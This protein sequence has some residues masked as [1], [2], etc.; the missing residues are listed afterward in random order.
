MPIIDAVFGARMFVLSLA[1]MGCDSSVGDSAEFAEATALCPGAEPD[2]CA[3]ERRMDLSLG[4][5]AWDG[6][7]PWTE[8][9]GSAWISTVD[10]SSGGAVDT[11]EEPWLYLR[12]EDESWSALGLGDLAAEES[13]EWDLALRRNL[14]RMNSGSSGPG[15]VQGLGLVGQN[16]ELIEELADGLQFFEEA[17][18]TEECQ[19]ISDSSGLPDVP[20]LVLD[21]WW[22]DKG[23]LAMTDMPMLLR[24]HSGGTLKLVIETYYAEGQESCDAGEGGASEGGRFR[25]RW[26]WLSP[27]G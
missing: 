22:E 16:F 14:I 18:Y 23:C 12:I 4:T 7:A 2:S 21:G 24:P 9:D 11:L 1:L 15:C 19:L 20:R 17:F 8:A 5:E 26:Q 3:Q 25:F 13:L 27:P 10:A 6:D